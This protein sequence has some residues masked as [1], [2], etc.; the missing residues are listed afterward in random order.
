MKITCNR[1]RLLAAFQTA[2]TVAAART[3]KAILQNVKMEAMGT[4]V[5]LTATD[6]EVGIRVEL[7][8]QEVETP[9]NALLSVSQFGSILRE[10]SDERIRIESDGQG[11]R[12][13]GER[14]RFRL[15]S[16]NPA[17]FPDFAE[18]KD[19]NYYTLP[20][21]LLRELIRR[22]L[23]ATDTDSGRYALG[24]VLLE[25]EEDRITAVGTDGRRLAKMEGP[26]GKVGT[27][28]SSDSMT[29][30]PARSMQLIERAIGDPEQEVQLLTRGNE[31]V[32]RTPASTI[33]TRLLE[34]RFPRWRDVFPKRANAISIELV[35]GPMLSAVRQAAIV[36][37]ADSRG[38]DF[39]FGGGQLIISGLTA[40]V[41]ESRVEL[42][43][44]YDGSPIELCLDHRFVTDFLR[45][46]DAD[47]TFRMSIVDSD[48]AALCETD[49][50][51]GYVVMPLARER[52]S[53]AAATPADAT[54]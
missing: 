22:T 54:A 49:D 41:G 29:I 2:A 5:T 43:I 37:S 36:T 38:V 24:G 52:V 17:E 34:G 13:R 45:V 10:S 1:D 18:P 53:R 23:F 31:F 12:I 7:D 11:V 47:R 30:V 14:S 46:L 4:R 44:S 27:P 9:G 39:I 6:L 21:R 42:P 20:G 32:V 48:N 19:T 8:D 15:P 25:M 16:Q 51:Y 33:V 26:I 3:S 28:F 40:D 35:V 50:G